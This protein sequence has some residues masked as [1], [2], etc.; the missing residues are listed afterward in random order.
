MAHR[1]RNGRDA[2]HVLG[3]HESLRCFFSLARAW[4]ALDLPGRGLNIFR[5]GVDRHD[6]DFG[7]TVAL[8]F[9]ERN[10]P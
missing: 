6:L 2:P 10:V 3:D 5:E 4:A 8:R 7:R 9:Y 1:V